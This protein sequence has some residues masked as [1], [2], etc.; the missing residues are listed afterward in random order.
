MSTLGVG[1][2][3]FPFK[4]LDNFSKQVVCICYVF[5]GDWEVRNSSTLMIYRYFGG[6]GLLIISVMCYAS[7]T[8]FY[9]CFVCPLIFS[10]VVITS[11]ILLLLY[12]LGF[13]FWKVYLW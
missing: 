11:V 4:N 6:F 2:L 8:L 1:P 13:P 9:S 5:A 7:I 3:C 10:V 12:F